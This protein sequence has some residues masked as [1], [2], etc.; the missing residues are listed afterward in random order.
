VEPDKSALRIFTGPSQSRPSASL[1]GKPEPIGFVEEKQVKKSKKQKA[2]SDK[3]IKKPK[4]K[5]PKNPK[6]DIKPKEPKEKEPN[7]ISLIPVFE[8][9]EPSMPVISQN[10]IVIKD[11]ISEQEKNLPA[12]RHGTIRRSGL[13]I[14]KAEEQAEKKRIEQ[15]KEWEIPAFLRKVKFKS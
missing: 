6:K 12:G 7:P 9:P 13:E 14:R 11:D 15:E 4:N 2:K 3:P 8:A 5:K 10:K 1:V